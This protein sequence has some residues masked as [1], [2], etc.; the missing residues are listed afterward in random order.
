MP[1]RGMG[2]ARE[3]EP[4]DDPLPV[5]GDEDGRVGMPP[6]RPQ[7][8]PLVGDAAPRLG[9]QQPRALLAADLAR[10]LDERLRVTRLGGADPRSRDDDPVTAAARVAG[11]GERPVRRAARRRRRRRRR[12]SGPPTAFTVCPA[13]LQLLRR[14]VG[15]ATLELDDAVLDVEPRALDRRRRPAG[16][17]RRRAD[18]PAGSP[19]RGRTEPALPTTSRGAAAVENER[20]S[21]HARQPLAGGSLARCRS[22]RARRACC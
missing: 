5:L 7:V 21:H 22:R 16:R 13:S 6:H 3:R 11:G 1:A 20:R 12:G 9:G 19:P 10:E 8:A 17:R 18:R 14:L 4:A 15:P 2:V